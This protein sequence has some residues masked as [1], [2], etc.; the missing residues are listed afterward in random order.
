MDVTRKRITQLVAIFAFLAMTGCAAGTAESVVAVPLG[1]ASTTDTTV[2][3]IDSPA[4]LNPVQVESPVIDRTCTPDA[5]V[6]DS[7]DGRAA[8][9]NPAS[10]AHNGPDVIGNAAEAIKSARQAPD[11]AYLDKARSLGWDEKMIAE[12]KAAAVRMSY[13]D[14]VLAEGA[15]VVRGAEAVINPARCVWVVTLEEPFI[16]TRGPNGATSRVFN[17][18]TAVIDQASGAGIEISAGPES[19]NVLTGQ[20]FQI[21]RAK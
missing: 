16:Q 20:G 9:A 18:Y 21:L 7:H 17:S 8:I 10:S 6:G 5:A 2:V 19:I 11:E 14:V 13:E 12:P 1:G 4:D 3:G 15:E